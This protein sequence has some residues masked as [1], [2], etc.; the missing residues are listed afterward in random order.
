MRCLTQHAIIT[1]LEDAA[2]WPMTI[3]ELAASSYD[4]GGDPSRAEIE[5][6]RR[7]V[8]VLR[9]RG[10]VRTRRV[11]TWS[12]TRTYQRHRIV[13]RAVPPIDGIS[14]P[15]VRRETTSRTVTAPVAVLWVTLLPRR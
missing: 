2:G 12:R 14:G 6:T 9:D 11:A 1:V 13:F 8:R 15:S 10:A 3:L 7:A 4:C 5:A